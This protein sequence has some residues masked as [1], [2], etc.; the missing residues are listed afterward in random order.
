METT[1]S[2][3]GITWINVSANHVTVIGCTD[4]THTLE[5]LENWLD[6]HW[7]I[8]GNRWHYF[9]V[10]QNIHSAHNHS[11]TD[12]VAFFDATTRSDEFSVCGTI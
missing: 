8:T 3:I 7:F 10:D 2:G 4:A 9:H 1:S 11:S 12:D 5:W 6:L